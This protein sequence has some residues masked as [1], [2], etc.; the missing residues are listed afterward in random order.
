MLDVGTIRN[1]FPFLGSGCIY[2][3]STSLSLTPEPVLGKMLEYYREY[4]ANVGRGLYK[5]AYC[6]LNAIALGYPQRNA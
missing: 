3:D 4:R 5:A 2:L 1:D 6:I